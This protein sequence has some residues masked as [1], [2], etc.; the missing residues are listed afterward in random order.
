MDFI[1]VE[2]I[3]NGVVQLF[4]LPGDTE[5]SILDIPPAHQILIHLNTPTFVNLVYL[6]LNIYIFILYVCM[7]EYIYINRCLY[8]YIYTYINLYLYQYQY[9]CLCL[10]VKMTG[11]EI[12]V[13]RF[14]G[15]IY[16]PW[17]HG[18]STPRRPGTFQDHP[19]NANVPSLTSSKM[20]KCV[21]AVMV[22]WLFLSC[23]HSCGRFSQLTWFTLIYRSIG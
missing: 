15:T 18:K 9:S 19:A 11:G 23:F 14:S 17:Q 22:C 10:Y 20:L 1:G 16:P 12:R 3:K 21:M 7:F 8:I 6:Y 5:Q 13:T 2:A 4:C